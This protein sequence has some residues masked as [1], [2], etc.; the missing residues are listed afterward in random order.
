M[1]LASKMKAAMPQRRSRRM[2]SDSGSPSSAIGSHTRRGAGSAGGGGQARYPPG[3]QQMLLELRFGHPGASRGRRGVPA[4]LLQRV[5]D[6][7]VL[8]AV[9]SAKDLVMHE[10]LQFLG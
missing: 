7:V 4:E 2:V 5:A 3:L 10:P 1:P 6:D 8:G 9:A